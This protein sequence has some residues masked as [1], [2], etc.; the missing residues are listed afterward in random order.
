MKLVILGLSKPPRATTEE[1]AQNSTRRFWLCWRSSHEELRYGACS[2]LADREQP[3]VAV[4]RRG[5]QHHAVGAASTSAASLLSAAD[6]D[7]TPPWPTSSLCAMSMNRR[8]QLAIGNMMVA[9][10][11]ASKA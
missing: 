4:V 10:I 6:L 2:K 1:A 9:P 8:S 11:H 5:H 7:L 3:R